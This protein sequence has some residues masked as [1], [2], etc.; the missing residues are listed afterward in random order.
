MIFSNKK[1]KII[2][3]DEADNAS[4]FLYS[5]QIKMDQELKAYEKRLE[6]GGRN[7][8]LTFD[9]SAETILPKKVKKKIKLGKKVIKRREE[10]ILKPI[11]KAYSNIYKVLDSYHDDF[12]HVL[13]KSEKK[14]KIWRRQSFSS[15]LKSSK[16]KEG[17]IRYGLWRHDYIR[18]LV[19]FF[20]VLVLLIVPFKLLAYFHI[21]NF[22]ELE[23]KVLT[24][25]KSAISN[26]AQAGSS[27]ANLEIDS[28]SSNFSSASSDFLAASEDMSKISDVLLKLASLS[29]DPKIK[30][31][32]ESKHFLNAGWHVSRLGVELSQALSGLDGQTETDWLKLLD[33]FLANGD[34]ALQDAYGLRNELKLINIKNLPP[35]YQDQFLTLTKQIDKL[36]ENLTLMIN[37]AKRLRAFLGADADK[38]YLLIFQNNAE[39]RGSGGFLGSYALI[40]FKQGKI[41]NLEVPGG[42]SYD[43]EAG[44]LDQIKSPEPLQLVNP[45]WYFWD[46]NWWPDFPTTAK[47]LMW[48]YEKSDG[49]SVDGVI[50]F[51]PSVIESLLEISG[52]IDLTKDYGVVITAENFWQEVQLTTERQHVVKIN[53]QA[54]AHLPVGEENKPKKIIGDLMAKMMEVLPQKMSKENLI[55]FISLTEQNLSSKQL[56]FYFNDENLQQEITKYHFDGAIAS[57][58]QDYLMVVNTNIAGA[59]TD[60][61]IKEEISHETSVNSDGTMFDTVT[62]KRTHTAL[63]NTPLV[64]VRNV[65]WLRIYVPL[66]SDLLAFSGVSVPDAKYFEKPGE[67]WLENDFLAK[68]EGLAVTDERTGTKIYEENGKTVFANWTMLD[69]G[70]T[71]TVVLRY[72][73][74]FNLW[75]V[76]S[77]QDFMG[78]LDNWLS[79]DSDT[80]YPYSLLVQKQPG[81]I[82][83]YFKTNLIIPQAYTSLWQ[84]TADNSQFEFLNQDKFFSGLISHK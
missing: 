52:P 29:S 20:V 43:T 25:T 58:S 53:P 71:S 83:Q 59:K 67:N 38:R 11:K 37:Q 21:L 56:M 4:D 82:N 27:F 61:V 17:R 84:S 3:L 33:N 40:D 45:R 8:A 74:P 15:Y 75:Q 55:K 54:V 46:A 9:F 47:N 62:I 70:Q 69:P 19:Y 12:D 76:S 79:A 68:H 31:A 26:L 41:K 50:S 23:G 48:F 28:A 57:T 80:F 36:P 42:G 66:G 5:L 24:K 51:T 72:R 14:L 64:G 49:P 39:M 18:S 73:L 77:R 81:S 30:L 22:N 34:L 63:K 32:A 6:K 7:A 16:A 13:K 2:K 60:K 10:K 65:N 1:N 44:M 35:E 78:R